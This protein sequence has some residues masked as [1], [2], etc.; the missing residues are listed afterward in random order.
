MERQLDRLLAALPSEVREMLPIW[1]RQLGS[2]PWKALT[3]RTTDAER[4]QLLARLARMPEADQ[5]Q[6]LLA[7][8]AEDVRAAKA[9]RRRRQ[10]ARKTAAGKH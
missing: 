5:Q 9:R 4:R 10:R 3:P 8:Y 6:L 7:M 2:G 1:R